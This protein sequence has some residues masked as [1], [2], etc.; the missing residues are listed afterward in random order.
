MSC[1]DLHVSVGCRQ[2]PVLRFGCDKVKTK[3]RTGRTTSPCMSSCQEVQSRQAEN[4]PSTSRKWREL[5]CRESIPSKRLS[6]YSWFLIL[7]LLLI[8]VSLYTLAAKERYFS[9]CADLVIS[10]PC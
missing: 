7:I 10:S 5:G 6:L 2:V 9:T 1:F 3:S 8:F 4:H